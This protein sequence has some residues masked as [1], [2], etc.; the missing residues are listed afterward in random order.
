MDI[1]GDSQL[2][3]FSH[4]FITFSFKSLAGFLFEAAK[5][6]SG[7]GFMRLTAVCIRT[8][9]PATIYVLGIPI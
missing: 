1:R 8:C 5:T 6:A 3:I 9:F 7:V 2:V 4:N